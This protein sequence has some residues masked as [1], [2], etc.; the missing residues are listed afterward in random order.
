[1]ATK[2]YYVIYGITKEYINAIFGSNFLKIFEA[3]TI[4]ISLVIFFAKAAFM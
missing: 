3:L 2:P 1:M 4:F